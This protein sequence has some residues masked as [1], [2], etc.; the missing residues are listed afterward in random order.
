MAL[1]SLGGT[2]KSTVQKSGEGVRKS[3]EDIWDGTMTAFDGLGGS[4]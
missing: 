1:S 4:R 3:E 2:G